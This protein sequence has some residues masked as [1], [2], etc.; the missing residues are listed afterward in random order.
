MILA[1]IGS[2]ETIKCSSAA[3]D[4]IDPIQSYCGS[5]KKYRVKEKNNILL[6]FDILSVNLNLFICVFEKIKKCSRVGLGQIKILNVKKHDQLIEFLDYTPDTFNNFILYR[7]N[8]NH[9]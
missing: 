7:R 8:T 1:A 3:A 9:N 4:E 5:D 2:S 6:F